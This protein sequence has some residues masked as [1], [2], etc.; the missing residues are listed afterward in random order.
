MEK[1]RRWLEAI[2]DS[3]AQNAIVKLSLYSGVKRL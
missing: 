2:Y 1:L 3:N